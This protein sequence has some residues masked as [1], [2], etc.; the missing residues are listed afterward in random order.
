MGKERLV[1]DDGGRWRSRLLTGGKLVVGLA[2]LAIL[3]DK[4]D[5][6]A[7]VARLASV[8]LGWLVLVLLLPHVGI[9]LST[10]KWRILLRRSGVDAPMTRLLALYL[11]GTFFNN[12]LPTMVGGDVVK[13]YQ[14]GRES[15]DTASVAAATFMERYLGL[16]ALISLLPLILFQD[17]VVDAWPVVRW[18]VGFAVLGFACTLVAFTPL[19]TALLE[20]E[21]QPPVGAALLPALRKTARKITRFRHSPRAVAISLV[22]SL[23][24]YL[25]TAASSWAAL[26]S[27]GSEVGFVYMLSI[28]PLVLLAALVPVSLNGLGITEGGYALLLGLAGVPAVSAVA[29]ALVLRARV[30]FTAGLGGLIF[31]LY[32]SASRPDLTTEVRDR[33]ASANG[34]PASNS[35]EEG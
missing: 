4:A 3:V 22:V 12:F 11:V 13:A 9:W 32:G 25:V 17:Q 34:F 15:G 6:R 2:L 10:M 28:V 26:R 33:L 8:D 21:W 20:R 7:L 5:L 23:L 27:V 24:F 31:L 16:A 35:N 18:I 30:L 19:G 14:L 1:S 29:M